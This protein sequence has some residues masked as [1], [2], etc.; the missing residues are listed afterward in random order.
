MQA[1]IAKPQNKL[2]QLQGELDQLY[3]NVL[4]QLGETDSNYIRRVVSIKNILEYSGR[5]LILGG[6][7]F[8]NPVALV[9]GVLSLSASQII[10]SMEIGHNVLHG[11]YDFLKRS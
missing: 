5:L 11:Q 6:A 4:G 1:R 10:E 9:I 7:V 2:E 3:I 8:W